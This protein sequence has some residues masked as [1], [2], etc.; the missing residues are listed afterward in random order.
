MN[1]SW[2]WNNMLVLDVAIQTLSD[3]IFF[4]S[5]AYYSRAHISGVLLHWFCLARGLLQS[6][7]FYEFIMLS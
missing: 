2:F 5:D 4:V 1:V 7:G 3:N 6:K